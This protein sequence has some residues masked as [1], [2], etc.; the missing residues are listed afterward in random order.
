MHNLCT[1]IADLAPGSRPISLPLARSGMETGVE[2]RVV[3][4]PP[5]KALVVLC[6]MGSS[7]RIA[8][9]LIYVPIVIKGQGIDHFELMNAVRSICAVAWFCS[10]ISWQFYRKVG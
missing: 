8:F 10:M 7:A 9:L 2:K 3:E 4:C 6:D 1:N 5:D